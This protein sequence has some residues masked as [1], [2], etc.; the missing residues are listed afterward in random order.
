MTSTATISV[1]ARSADPAPLQAAHSTSFPGLLRRLGA[2]LL[3]TTYKAVTLLP[4]R[5][6]PELINH[7]EALLQNSF[8]VPDAALL[9][10]PA[11]LRS[12]STAAAHA[13]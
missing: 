8:V 5:R 11:A 3:V 12:P 4:G 10:V 6:W 9:D 13:A 2:S 1:C 7:D